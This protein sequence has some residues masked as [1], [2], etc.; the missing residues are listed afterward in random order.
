MLIGLFA[1][2]A[3]SS[4]DE[5]NYRLATED[6]EQ[7]EP[8]SYEDYELVNNVFWK[9]PHEPMDGMTALASSEL[10]MVAGS[11]TRDGHRPLFMLRVIV[12][13]DPVL[14]VNPADRVWTKNDLYHRPYNYENAGWR[15]TA[16]GVKRTAALGD[17]RNWLSLHA[18]EVTSD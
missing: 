11:V 16:Q 8:M 6:Y 9:A 13:G 12:S 1:I 7:L 3:C 14:F 15:C 10:P 4:P 2:T 5:R 18:W 17:L